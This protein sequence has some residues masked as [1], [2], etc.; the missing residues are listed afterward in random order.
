MRQAGSRSGTTQVPYTMQ[1]QKRQGT[2]ATVST[3]I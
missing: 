1:D 3:A 2:W